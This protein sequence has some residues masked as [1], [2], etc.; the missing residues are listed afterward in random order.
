[1]WEG[2]SLS[3]LLTKEGDIMNLESLKTTLSDFLETIG[4]ELYDVE[5]K[6]KT[7]NSILTIFIDKEEGI[8]LDDCVSVT[9]QINP[10]IDELDPIKEEY[11]LE[12]SSPGAEKE[13]RTEKAILSNLT[14]FVHLETDVEKLEG[15]LESYED[16]VITLKVG[17]N[18]KKYNY[19]DVSLLRLAI[20]F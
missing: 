16:G 8:T 2:R 20:K 12:V 7:K 4:Y 14:K 15:Y 11:F 1:M 10:L 17:K 5:Y 18:I 13:L 9:E 3:F 19:K 6:K